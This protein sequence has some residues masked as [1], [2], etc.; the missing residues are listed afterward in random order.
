LVQRLRKSGC[1]IENRMEAQR[2]PGRR[3]MAEVHSWY[4]LLKEPKD[5]AREL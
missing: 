2:E 3:G 5:L 4:R 1:V